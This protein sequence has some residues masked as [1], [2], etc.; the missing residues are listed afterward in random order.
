MRHYLKAAHVV[1]KRELPE[2]ED[3]KRRGLVSIA[4]LGDFDNAIYLCVADHAAFDAERPGLVIVP[5]FLDFLLEQERR[6]QDSMKTSGCYR[7]PVSATTYAGH[8]A[9]QT[10]TVKRDYTQH[11]QWWT[12]RGRTLL[13]PP[14]EFQ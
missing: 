11:T 12:T 13:E 5:T 14:T 4:T 3:R 1:D 2:Y 9:A 7:S 6:W 8:C 10:D